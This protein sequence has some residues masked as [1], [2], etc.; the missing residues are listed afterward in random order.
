MATDKIETA[1]EVIKVG[2]LVAFLYVA[3]REA[4]FPAAAWKP[5]ATL[6][7]GG[8]VVGAYFAGQHFATTYKEGWKNYLVVF[9]GI[10]ILTLISWAGL[11]QHVEDADPVFGGGEVVQDFVPTAVER[12]NHAINIFVVLL[13]PALIGMYRKRNTEF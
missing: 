13:V 10:G 3:F 6:L 5:L 9:Y 8:L 2:V 1:I 4:S 11:G 12:A 7:K